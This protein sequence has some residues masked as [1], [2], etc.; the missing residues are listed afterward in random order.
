LTQLV[1]EETNYDAAYILGYMYENGEGV[2]K[3]LKKF[4]EYYKFSS[5]R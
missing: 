1:E 5:N 4:Q 3:N 2:T